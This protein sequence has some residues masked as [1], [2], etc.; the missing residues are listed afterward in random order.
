M[1]LASIP[2]IIIQANTFPMVTRAP[3]D[4]S[5]PA[6][7]MVRVCPMDTIPKKEAILNTEFT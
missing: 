5:I 4:R 6:V 3:T 1:V 7:R 2:L